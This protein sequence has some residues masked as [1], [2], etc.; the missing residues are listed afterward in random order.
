MNLLP[1]SA[2]QILEERARALARPLE[3]AAAVVSP[4]E[5]LTFSR[6]GSAYAIDGS[7]AVAVVPIADP[8]PVPGTP[9]AV[10][11]VV[12]HR[13]RILAVVDV[14][15]LVAATEREGSPAALGIVVATGGASFV[16]LADTVPELVSLGAGEVAAA[17]R[18]D[19]VVRGVT[20]TMAAVLDLAA[21]ARDPRIAVDDEME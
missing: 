10:L 11:G 17:E 7:D 21:L 1:A 5:L 12:N 19:G 9:Q 2:R 14:A 3:E 18:P 6:G 16:L 4:L 15:R 20:P 8:T 13:G